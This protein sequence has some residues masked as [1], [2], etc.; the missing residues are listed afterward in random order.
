MATLTVMPTPATIGET[1][2]ARSHRTLFQ[3]EEDLQALVDSIELV[4]AEQEQDF[5]A[6]L[7]KAMLTAKEKRDRVNAFIAQC[8]GQAAIA[9]AEIQRLRKRQALYLACVEQMEGYVLHVIMQRAPDEKGR[10]PKLV[11]NSST[12]AAQRNPPSV[13]I[14]DEAQV[15]ASC[16]TISVTMSALLW[17][18]LCDSLDM[19][20]C[21]QVLDAV[22]KPS[23]AVVKALVKDAIAAELPDWK[24][25]LDQKPSVYCESVPGAA[26]AAGDYRLV[27]S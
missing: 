15:P 3:V 22:K 1:A 17:E 24:K 16:K 10:Y 2:V 21:S 4:A 18:Q 23:T 6:D 14:T 25:Q 13:T 8:E 9:D 26:I 19:D 20:F 5:L 12:F 7:Q 27:R 11:G